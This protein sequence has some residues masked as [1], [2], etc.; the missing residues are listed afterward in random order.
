MQKDVKD[1]NALSSINQ[2][3]PKTYTWDYEYYANGSTKKITHPAGKI[4]TF[5]YDERGNTTAYTLG[6][7]GGSRQTTYA[8]DN[9]NRLLNEI[10]EG[11]TVTVDG[12]QHVYN[13]IKRLT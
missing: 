2:G 6:W 8:Y 7:N 11:R 5:Q 9:D 1:Y 4:E 3:G 12:V 13:D 10:Q